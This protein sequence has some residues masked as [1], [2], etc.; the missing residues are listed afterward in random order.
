M[1]Q[2]LIIQ[3]AFPAPPA[4]LFHAWTDANRLAA[5][6]A[7]FATVS[8]AEKRY[9][10]W[11]RFT[12]EAPNQDQGHHPLLAFEPAHSLKFGWHVHNAQTIVEIRLVPQTTPTGNQTVLI[13]QH[14]DA[15][16]ALNPAEY[17]LE[18]FWFLSLENLRRHLAGQPPVRCNFAALQPGDIHHTIEIDAPAATVFDILIRPDQLDRWIASQATVEP[19]IGGQYSFGWGAPLK[20]LELAPN[21]KLAC[22]W[23]E[24]PETIVTWTLAE[25]GGKTWL[26]LVHSGFAPD[27]PT[28]GLNS[29]WL[30]FMSWIKAIAETGPT[31]TPP[32]RYLPE[33][34]Q[35]LYAASIAAGQA[36]L[37]FP[38]PQPGSD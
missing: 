35:H 30:N 26:T 27:T 38:P 21:E 36:D 5:W 1:T 8:R 23:P 12:P 3:L 15:P 10:F 17:T 29:G 25:S 24:E 16:Q 33:E 31:W 11:G 34:M 6:F 37:L 18:D 14:G 2:P 4:E 20:I 19:R 22:V 13:L 28:L 7:E 9:D 32:I